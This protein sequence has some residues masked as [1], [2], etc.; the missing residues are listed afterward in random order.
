MIDE[1]RRG[2][3]VWNYLTAAMLMEAPVATS[4]YVYQ[5]VDG[6]GLLAIDRQSGELSW[7]V[8]NGVALLSENGRKVYVMTSDN[9]LVVMDERKKQKIG[10][11]SLVGVTHWV[12]NIW[13]QRIYLADKYGRIVCVKPIEY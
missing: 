8:P 3:L 9:T 12:S 6:K 2:K 11:V 7:R 5:H 4:R 10:E 1:R 13:G